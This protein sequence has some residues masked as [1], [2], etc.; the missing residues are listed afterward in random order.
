MKI[1]NLAVMLLPAVLTLF[2]APPAA[3]APLTARQKLTIQQITSVF[4]NGTPDFRY[5]YI[6]DINDGAG[7]TCGRVGFTVGE[8]L[9]V[10]D[11]YVKAK[12]RSAPLAAWL[13]C[14]RRMGGDISKDYSCLFPSVP[15]EKL[16]TQEFKEEGG[17]I[18]RN[19]FGRDW[20]AA[21][22]DPVMRK[23]QDA[24]VEETYF[25]PALKAAW[26]LGLR[27]PLGIACAYD[28]IIQMD[29]E[30]LFKAIGGQFAAAHG[31]RVK[32]AGEAEEASWLRLY[33]AE[34]KKELS[35]TP[36]GAATTSRVDALGQIL[37]SGN[38]DLALPIEFQ[39]SG[40]T[41]R[42]TAAGS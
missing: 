26:D 25:K 24:Y 5:D 35:V 40:N 12:G 20:V 27:T 36:V 3:A 42:L 23:V 29:T 14:L 41:F 21:G 19:D 6:E 10:T 8:L 17:L 31:G 39:Y 1:M 34:R 9:L 15:R 37:D 16:P 18:A 4:E 2:S 11:R 38:F 32:P 22:A 13:P 7:I 30:P 28:A 33:L